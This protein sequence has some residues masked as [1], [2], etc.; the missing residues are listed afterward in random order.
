MVQLMQ[1][2]GF[3]TITNLDCNENISKWVSGSVRRERIQ[4]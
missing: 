3:S 1:N 4:E 2:V